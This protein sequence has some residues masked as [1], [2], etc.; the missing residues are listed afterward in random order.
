[1]KGG[2][3]SGT[4]RW[5]LASV[6]IDDFR[7]ILGSQ[8]YEF[9]G[10]PTIIWGNN[11]V[12]KSTVAL[13]LEWT[14]FGAFPSNALGAPKDSFMTPVGGEPKEWKGEV[15]FIR[16]KDRLVVCRDEGMNT[17]T[18]DGSGK[19]RSGENAI[20]FLEEELGLDMETFVRAVLLQQSKIRGLLLDDVKDRNKALDR[21]LG[22][23]AAEVMLEAIRP[24]P[25]KDAAKAWREDIQATEARYESQATLLEK[26]FNDTQKE[27]REHKFL[28]KDL[29]GAGLALLYAELG[30]DLAKIAGKYGADAPQLLAVETVSVAKKVSAA[31]AKS[32]NQ[33]RLGA[34]VHKKLIPIEKRLAS[35]EEATEQWMEL[36][37]LRD[38]AQK[39]FD[40]IVK[41]HGD[42]KAIGMR[43][44]A[45]EKE[46]VRM[47]EQLRSAGELRALLEQARVYFEGDVVESCPVC[48][49]GIA[50]PRKTLQNLRDRIDGLTTKSVRD[51]EKA[52]GKAR[53]EHGDL[54]EMEKK[55]QI[56][57]TVLTDAQKEVESERKGI[58]KILDI[59]GL[60]EKRVA[61]E[62][63]KAVAELTKQQSDL[64]KGAET[65]EKDLDTI[66]DRDR[67][68]RDG[69]VP[70]LE[71]REEV[72]AHEREWKKAKKRYGD[73]EK[74]ANDLDD[75]A[76]QVENIRKAVL[77]AKDEIASETLG[78]AG[79]RAQTLYKKLVQHPLFD[80]LDVKT[81][82]R[83]NK[84]DYSF[85][86]SSSVEGKSAREAR[87]VLSDGQMTA[88]ALALF[89]SL[90]ESGQHGL[91]LLYVDDPTQNL[92]HARKEAMAK[93]VVELASRKQIVVST[94]DEDFVVLLR[95][96][97]FED[98]NVVHHIVEWDRRP[99]VST[100]MPRASKD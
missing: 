42:A 2:T 18:V 65:L 78:K 51:I 68:I 53:A 80:R 5:R 26:R 47:Q 100:T 75:L 64:S 45:L 43:R 33:I 44:M 94:Q 3:V 73:A 19:K 49:Q 16:G 72:D 57:Q 61:T 58:M 22:M 69:L 34:E 98:G 88:A 4:E 35:F 29:S 97:G 31:L 23:D 38:E 8:V 10:R 52:L 67:D 87:L 36:I 62:L 71:A 28:G 41:K 40:A 92:D 96:A 91:D 48:E 95:D 37:E 11:G 89:F 15:V 30:S 9:N 12:G 54:C 85:E 27:A 7:G 66:T 76:T 25:F 81:A 24:K 86:V 83:A 20:A 6:T 50:Q 79:P 39:E 77:A 55:L 70:F 84:V 1:M 60:V 46:F 99:T 21:L 56:A 63:S 14:L 32:V 74:K 90:A 17:F 59:D 13:A 82:R 93:V